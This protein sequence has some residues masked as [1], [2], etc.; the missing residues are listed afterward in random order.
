[1]IM[2]MLM[3]MITTIMMTTIATKTVI[4]MLMATTILAFHYLQVAFHY[5]NMVLTWSLAQDSRQASAA[6]SSASSSLTPFVF[7]CDVNPLSPQN[8]STFQLEF[9]REAASTKVKIKFDDPI[10]T[11]PTPIYHQFSVLNHSFF[12]PPPHS[13]SAS[14]LPPTKLARTRLCS[15]HLRL[16]GA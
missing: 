15:C 16:V 2:T 8:N 6:A 1:M 14:T 10:S 7:W 13:Y 9:L 4:E 5:R 11:P 3:M 12:Q